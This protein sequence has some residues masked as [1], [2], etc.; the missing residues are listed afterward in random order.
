MHRRSFALPCALPLAASAQ[1][2]MG[3][4]SGTV[5][6]TTGAALSQ[7]TVVAEELRYVPALRVDRSA[8][9]RPAAQRRD[10]GTTLARDASVAG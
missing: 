3:S 2:G 7:A 5:Q 10:S 9:E 6:D 1:A 8:P 4:I